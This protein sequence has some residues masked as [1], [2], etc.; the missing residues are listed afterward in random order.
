[1]LVSSKAFLFP[2]PSPST[3]AR[4]HNP[5]ELKGIVVLDLLRTM[6]MPLRC[7]VVRR[8]SRPFVFRGPWAICR[9]GPPS[10]FGRS[11]GAPLFNLHA[12]I[13][14][15]NETGGRLASRPVEIVRF[16]MFFTVMR[17][18]PWPNW[19][20]HRLRANARGRRRNEFR[21]QHATVSS[22]RR[23]LENFRSSRLTLSNIP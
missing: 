9:F 4:Q 16:R 10:R 3:R 7:P 13:P 23:F 12:T 2:S 17:D 5:R 19:M 20:R 18:L 15:R 1:M 21:Q 14:S 11:F 6:P 22:L 8:P